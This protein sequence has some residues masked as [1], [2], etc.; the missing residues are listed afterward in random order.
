[1]KRKTTKKILAESFREL[2]ENRPVDKIVIHRPHGQKDMDVWVAVAF[3]VNGKV[4]DHTAGN[5]LF[6]AVVADK[7]FIFIFRDFI[8]QRHDDAAGKLGVPLPF[9]LLHGIP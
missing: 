8:R 1:M 7:G 2:A 5:K 3:V 4:H 9:G 6:P